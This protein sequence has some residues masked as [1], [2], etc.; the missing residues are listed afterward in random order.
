MITSQS[1]D[2]SV[3]FLRN[4]KL[5]QAFQAEKKSTLK[6]SGGIQYHDLFRKIPIVQYGYTDTYDL[7]RFTDDVRKLKRP[8][9][10][11]PCIK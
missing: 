8:E 3:E 6:S 1:L 2:G 10:E 7:Q 9:C 4:I 5:R 11:G